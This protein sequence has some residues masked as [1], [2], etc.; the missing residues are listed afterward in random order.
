MLF[1]DDIILAA[2]RSDD[3]DDLAKWVERLEGNGL[4]R[5]KKTEYMVA[6][7][8]GVPSDDKVTIGNDR[9]KKVTEFKYL[10]EVMSYDGL[11]VGEIEQSIKSG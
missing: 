6:D 1:A 2:K 8:S 9:I 3:E 10:G 5:R 4:K 7:F 11:L